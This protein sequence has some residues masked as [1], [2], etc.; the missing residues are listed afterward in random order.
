MLFLVGPEPDFHWRAFCDAVVGLARSWR[1][2][3][4]GRA[5]GL[6]GAGAAH[7][8]GAA[9]GHRT[10]SSRPHLIEQVGVVQ[11]ELEVPAGVSAALEMAFGAPGTPAVTLWARVPHYVA[12]MPFPEA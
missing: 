7:P 9:G 3:H 1:V 6:P 5:G 8:A 12:G 10:R 4:G 11:G 2:R